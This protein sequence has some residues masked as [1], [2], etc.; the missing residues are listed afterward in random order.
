MVF[1]HPVGDDRFPALKSDDIPGGDFFRRG[2]FYIDDAVHRYLR[3]HACADHLIDAVP[4]KPGRRD[5]QAGSDD[6]QQHQGAGGIAEGGEKSPAFLS[7][8]GWLPRPQL[9][10]THCL[11]LPASFSG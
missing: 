1:H 7:F 2:F 3:L 10:L 4:C 8:S 11:P 6:S 5:G 9:L